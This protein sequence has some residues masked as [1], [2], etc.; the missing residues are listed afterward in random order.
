MIALK[1][2]MKEYLAK[3]V[4]NGCLSYILSQP[5][6]LDVMIVLYFI[7]HYLGVIQLTELAKRMKPSL[8]FSVPFKFRKTYQGT[9]A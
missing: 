3:D 9:P 6:E 7:F 8:S 4:V 2:M 5:V 1:Y